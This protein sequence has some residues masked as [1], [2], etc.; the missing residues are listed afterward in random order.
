MSDTFELEE[1]G[2]WSELKLEIVEQYGTAY[3]N[4]FNNTPGL[5]KYYIDGFSGAGLHRSKATGST[6]DGS[7]ARALRVSPPFDGYYFIDLDAKKTHYLKS[8]CGNR[9]DAEIFTGDC[10]EIL[11]NRLLPRIKYE[12][13]NRA[14]C[15]L[16][17]Y[18][19]HLEV[20]L[21][22]LCVF[23]TGAIWTPTVWVQASSVWLGGNSYFNCWA[24]SKYSI[25]LYLSTYTN[26]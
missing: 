14:L 17:P 12:N 22:L 7:P 25:I 16:D 5:K 21:R 6:V 1:I 13:F 15:L 2:V 3:T 10:N 23:L 20:T 8:I 4:A 19:L 24:S 18:G 11:K 9:D 26:P